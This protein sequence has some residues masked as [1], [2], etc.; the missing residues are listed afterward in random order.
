METRLTI[1]TRH[2][3]YKVLLFLI[4][5]FYFFHFDF[6]GTLRGGES[7]LFGLVLLWPSCLAIFLRLHLNRWWLALVAFNIILII[8]SN[9]LNAVS[10]VGSL[11]G[12]SNTLFVVTSVVG[13]FMLLHKNPLLI[14]FFY[15]GLLLGSF[16][17]SPY[18]LDF[19][20]GTPEEQFF[21]LIIA[22]K[23]IPLLLLISTYHRWSRGSFF[24][25]S[26]VLGLVALIANARSLGLVILLSSIVY[27]VTLLTNKRFSKSVYLAS[28]AVF[29]GFLGLG[30]SRFARSGQ[31][32]DVAQ[33]QIQEGVSA[34]SLLLVIGRPDPLIALVAIKDKPWIGHGSESDGQRYIRRTIGVR[35]LPKKY[36]DFFGYEKLKIPSHSVILG[37]AVE[38]GLFSTIAWLFVLFYY[39]YTL[40]HV[41]HCKESP[42]YFL[43]I[44]ACF[45]SFW[46]LLFSP[47]GFVRYDFPYLW[48]ASVLTLK[49]HLPHFKF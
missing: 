5:F 18:L 46:N 36:Q 37:A 14:R 29:V 44:F 8:W 34:L 30:Y 41:Q 7:I 24:L 19:S 39:M 27:G 11:K 28:L 49:K 9:Q 13:M 48:A 31:L 25:L 32:G 1:N 38:S 42:L 20:R 45:S 12:I 4:G 10:F 26:F 16:F 40:L 3:Q 35:F 21:D 6:V 43:V 23:I 17:S 33:S 2:M 47:F 22:P 15:G